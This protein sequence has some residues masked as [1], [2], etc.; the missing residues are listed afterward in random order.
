MTAG[1]ISLRTT[2][3]ASDHLRDRHNIERAPS[4]LARLRSQGGGP[5]F[6]MVGRRVLYAEEDLDDFA[7]QL[8]STESF[9]STAEAQRRYFQPLDRGVAA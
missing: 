6:R 8:I 7:R 1:A 9:A 2:P 3:Q 4:T 5:R